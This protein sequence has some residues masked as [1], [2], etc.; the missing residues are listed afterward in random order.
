MKKRYPLYVYNLYYLLYPWYVAINNVFFYVTTRLHDSDGVP[1]LN[2]LLL[3]LDKCCAAYATELSWP[4][5]I[6]Y[7][8]DEVCSMFFYITSV[9]IYCCKKGY[10]FIMS[11]QSTLTL[12]SVN[13]QW[14]RQILCYRCVMQVYGNA[15][16]YVK[17]ANKTDDVTVCSSKFDR[18]TTREKGEPLPFRCLGRPN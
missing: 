5:Q 18:I 15:V 9:I 16:H 2:F 14:Q 3:S 10:N 8:R 17:M 13:I 12:V 4:L 7:T 6:F 11:V 1:G